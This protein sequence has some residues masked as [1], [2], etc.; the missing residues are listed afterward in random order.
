ME[1]EIITGKSNENNQGGDTNRVLLQE[2][3]LTERATA[4][5][6]SPTDQN[7]GSSQP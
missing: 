1:K 2:V 7:T 4:E 5:K 3:E 6:A